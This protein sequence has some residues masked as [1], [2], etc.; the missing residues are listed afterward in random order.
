MIIKERLKT[1]IRKNLN[2][3]YLK[4]L[5][6]IIAMKPL[7]H[8]YGSTFSSISDKYLNIFS[9]ESIRDAYC[10]DRTVGFGSLFIPYEFLYSLR[11]T[12]FLPEVM[13][14]FTAGLGLAE[15][16]LAK[17]SS[18]W[19][20][21]DLC[22]FH[23]SASGAVEMD[24]FPKPSF[25]FSTNLACDA[26]QKSFYIYARKYGIEENFHLI[27]VPYEKDEASVSYLA[28]Q[29]R[30]IA[31]KISSKMGTGLD[32]ARFREVIQLSNRFREL[33]IEVNQ[34]RRKLV[35]YPPYYNGLNFILPFH[36]LTGT[37]NDVIL[38]QQMLLEL[39]NFLKEQENKG[40]APARKKLLWLHLKPYYRNDIFDTL[41]E[42][43]CS[44]V[45]EE[46]NHVYWPEM[47]PSSPFESFARKMLSN[48]LAGSI[49]HRLDAIRTMARDYSIDG[50]ILFSHW[51][52]RHSN[53]GARIIKDSL[54]EMGI[55][56]LVLDG[57]CVDA[58]NSSG[59]Q[60]KTRLQGFMEI[61]N[62]RK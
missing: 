43:N 42:G 9:I 30:E 51:G 47:D 26:A 41:A 22:T 54:K 57:D 29:F 48:P 59:G 24:L 16:T 27:D 17:A 58:G 4:R 21:Q 7:L 34:V 49:N 11:I 8:A 35:D 33:A 55:P 61:L 39:K 44:V 12:P 45:F 14:G 53:G 15:Q 62:F 3:Q 31:E 36:G 18:N 20:S 10:S 23:R 60:I 13:A 50:A 37:E 56:V 38:Y 28:G 19:Y 32:Y 46:I 52:C 6:G 1:G 25:I 2:Q 5:L 40:D